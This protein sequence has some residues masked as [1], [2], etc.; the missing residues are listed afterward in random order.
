MQLP[1]QL[2]SISVPAPEY[3]EEA[4]EAIMTCPS[5]E[6]L[7][8]WGFP[9]VEHPFCGRHGATPL[10]CSVGQFDSDSKEHLR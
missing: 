10:M 5:G 6:P 3:F 1:R 2:C 8:R 7:H 4:R 9:F